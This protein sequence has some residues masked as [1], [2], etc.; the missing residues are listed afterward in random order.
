DRG[1]TGHEHLD[2]FGL[3]NM[4]GRMYDPWVGRFLSPDPVLQ[5]P[6]NAQNHNRYSYALNNPLKYTDPS[7]YSFKPD[8]WD[9]PGALPG[10]G[11]WGWDVASYYRGNTNKFKYPVLDDDT[12]QKK[13]NQSYEYKIGDD[14]EYYYFDSN[15]KKVGYDEVFQ[16]YIVPNSTSFIPKEAR[17]GEDNKNDSNSDG[18]DPFID[19]ELN[20]KFG[21]AFSEK[22]KIIGLGQEFKANA[23]TFDYMTFKWNSNKSNIE[24]TPYRTATS[25]FSFGIFGLYGG[26]KQ[27]W[28]KMLFSPYG[29]L[30]LTY[31]ERGS[32]T[33]FNIID[34]GYMFGF[35]FDFKVTLSPKKV[36]NSYIEHQVE[37]NDKVGWSIYPF[38]H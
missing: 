22:L 2:A 34:I 7:G 27:D 17:E 9:A 19:A 36:I 4:N 14:G 31:L 11:T 16:N 26:I 5:Q 20:I 10:A 3:I 24:Y 21:L 35:G 29:Q 1:Y 23:I 30:G 8:D 32:P 33:R 18:Y 37:W 13:E 12:P 38:L 25:S 6:G 15:G 28:G